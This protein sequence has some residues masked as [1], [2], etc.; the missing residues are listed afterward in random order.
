[1]YSEAGCTEVDYD[2][3]EDG[4]DDYCEVELATLFAPD[5]SFYEGD[6]VGRE[7]RYAAEK[8]PWGGVRI[9]YLIG[10]YFDVGNVGYQRDLCEDFI[11]FPLAWLFGNLGF[12]DLEAVESCRGHVGDSEFVVLDLRFDTESHHWVVDKVYLSQHGNVETV[13]SGSSP[14]PSAFTYPDKLGGYP[15]VYVADG[16]HAGYSSAVACDNGGTLGFDACRS[17]RITSRVFI[18]NNNG[19]VGSAL[20]HWVDCI[21]TTNPL[22]PA[23][24]TSGPGTR[25]ECYWTGTEFRGWF[26]AD[27]NPS[28]D[29]YAVVLG[30]W[31]TGGFY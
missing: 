7:P 27:Y 20:H 26:A 21:G 16:K 25:S 23:T 1:M 11:A 8:L 3:D 24:L 29:S 5:L 28:S 14:Y 6:E 31:L 10:Y 13:S 19:N 18:P 22:H 12:F 30:T 15:L 4:L 17:P 2:A 9:V